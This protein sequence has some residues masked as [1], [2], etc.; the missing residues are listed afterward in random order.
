MEKESIRKQKRRFN[1]QIKESKRKAG[2]EK[3]FIGFFIDSLN[4]FKNFSKEKSKSNSLTPKLKD[5][6]EWL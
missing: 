1:E 2:V 3:S 6:G 4:P 5:E